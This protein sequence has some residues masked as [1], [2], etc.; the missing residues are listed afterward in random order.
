MNLE[1]TRHAGGEEARSII[2]ILPDKE[3]NQPSRVVER[4]ELRML[5]AE[6]VARAPRIEQMVLRLYF[7]EGMT[8]RQIAEID[9][10]FDF[11]RN[12]FKGVTKEYQID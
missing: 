6:V 9:Q 7:Q 12:E 10:V 1:R 8:L 11:L 3:E 4:H 5:L 2:D